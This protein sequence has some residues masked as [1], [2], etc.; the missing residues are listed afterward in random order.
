MNNKIKIVLFDI[1]GVFTDGTILISEDGKESKR[2][3]FK[4]IDAFFTLKKAGYKTGFITGEATPLTQWF[5]NRFAPDY[6]VSG[7]KDKGVAI[8]EILTK[9][10]LF[11]REACYIGDSKHDIPA[12]NVVGLKICPNNAVKEVQKICDIVLK[13]SGGDGAIA[14]LSKILIESIN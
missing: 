10:N 4:D 11:A 12:F 7:C 13:D 1:D 8:Q 3:S 14:E 2:I 6:F 5:N 9:E